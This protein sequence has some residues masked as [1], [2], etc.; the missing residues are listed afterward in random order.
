MTLEEEILDVLHQGAG[1]VYVVRDSNTHIYRSEDM[2]VQNIMHVNRPYVPW[3]I[4]TSVRE[5]AD[6]VRKI[7]LHTKFKMLAIELRRVEFD[8]GRD[9]SAVIVGVV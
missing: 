3:V 2:V 5:L 6:E 1:W 7:Q 9:Y 4:P 8:N